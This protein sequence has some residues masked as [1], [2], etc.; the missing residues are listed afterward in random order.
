M[1]AYEYTTTVITHGLMGRKGD[2][3][4]PAALTETLNQYGAEG[5]QL[6]KIL[7]DQAIH[8]GKD[9]HLVIFK[10]SLA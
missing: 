9:G 4:D 3:I 10:R 6:D 5:W 1:S 8:H 7:V 2:E